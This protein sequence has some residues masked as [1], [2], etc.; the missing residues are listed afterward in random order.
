[1][2]KA[3]RHADR[4]RLRTLAKTF[5]RMGNDPAALLCLDH[6]FLSPLK[7]QNLPLD[8][9]QASLSPYLDYIRLLNKFCIDKSLTEGSNHQRLFGFH[10][11]GE[12]RCLV[13]KHSPL[14]A[15][16]TNRSTS[17]GK[18]VDGYRCNYDELSRGI[19]QLISSR[20]YARTEAQNDACRDVHGFSPCLYLLVQNKCNPPEGKEPCTFQHVQTGQLT[21]G[22]YRARIRLILLQFQILDSACYYDWNVRKYVL[23]HFV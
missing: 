2:F 11:L 20:I 17:S 12:N 1:M 7:L 4:T 19:V 10:P 18:S 8:E 23:A 9:I 22:W 13:P 15:K 5:I 6:V 16:L 14:H 21:V 3:I